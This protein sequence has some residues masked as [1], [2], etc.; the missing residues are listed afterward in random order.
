MEMAG[1]A[2]FVRRHHVDT[3]LQIYTVRCK[4]QHFECKIPRF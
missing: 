1:N 4:I 2:I 3:E